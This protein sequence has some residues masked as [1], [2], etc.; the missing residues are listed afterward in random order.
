LTEKSRGQGSKANGPNEAHNDGSDG[1]NGMDERG[2]SEEKPASILHGGDIIPDKPGPKPEKAAAVP[3][4]RV[5]RV[6]P[7]GKLASPNM[8]NASQD[9]KPTKET[10]RVGSDG[11]LGSPKT[12]EAALDT[13][14]KRGRKPTETGATP[15][16]LVA[17][18]R[19]GTDE[20]SRSVIGRRVDDV[21]SG[22]KITSSPAKPK[23]SGPPGPPK[24]TH[25]FFLGGAVRSSDRVA[26]SLSDEQQGVEADVNSPAQQRKVV[27]PMKARVT[28][29]LAEF[30]DNAAAA[31][32]F[33][34]SR[35]GSDQ[36]RGSLFPGAMEPIWPPLSMLHVGQVSELPRLMHLDWPHISH[37]RTSCRK[38][39]GGEIVV[40]SEEEVLRPCLDLVRAYKVDKTVS[41]KVESCD[42]S[43]FRRPLR[44]LM[45]GYALQ[46]AVSQKLSA[47]IPSLHLDLNG[48][49]DVDE[50][51]SPQTHQ[52]QPH[53]ALRQVFEQIPISSTA[54]D[55]FE[56]E[57]QD[58]AHKYSP[59][60]AENVLQQGREVYLLRD[61]LRGLTVSSIENSDSRI[62]ESSI[63]CKFG[64]KAS[65]RKRRRAEKLEG[66][67]VSS[68]GESNQMDEI[69]DPEDSSSAKPPLR[70]TVIRG[71]NS[72]GLSSICDRSANAVV[73]S[74]PHGCGKTAAVYAVAQ[75]LNF[76]VFEINA[77]S[78]RS[79]KDIL[80]KVG[81]MTRNHLVKHASKEGAAM[82]KD[83]H[84]E[85]GIVNEKSKQD[86]EFGRHGKTNNF[87]KAKGPTKKKEPRSK[88]NAMKTSP[89]KHK[90]P[91]KQ[92]TQKQSLILLEEVDVLFEEDK[93][94]W[95]TILDLILHSKRP[96]IMT[97]TDEDFLPLDE[98]VLYAIL[99][100]TAPPEQFAIDYLLLI[101]CNEGHLLSRVAVS[102]LYR[103][104]GSDLRASM[105]EL[106]FFCQMAIGDTRGG[107]EWMLIRP[108]VDDSKAKK[109]EL[110][111]VVSDGTYQPFMGW[112]SGEDHLSETGNLID[113]EIELLSEVW[114]GWG[115]DIGASTQYI[116]GPVSAAAPQ[117]SR[118]STLESL[119]SFDQAAEALSAT[120]IFP[121]CVVRQP[122]N[123]ILEPALPEMTEKT[124]SNYVEGSNVLLADP[125]IDYG[126]VAESLSLTMRVCAKRLLHGSLH[127][128]ETLPSTNNEP[129]IARILP[130]IM[131]ERRSTMPMTKSSTSATFEPIARSTEP[132]LGV[133]KGLQIS[134]FDRPMS[135]I[136]VDLA[137]YLRNIV[138]YD[139]RLE[140][141]RR[142][143]DSL[144]PGAGKSGKN[145]RTT[146]SSR[147]ALEG[148]QKAYTRRERWFLNNTN[149]NLVLRSGGKDWQDA[150]QRMTTDAS[151]EFTAS[152]DL[153]LSRRSSVGSAVESDL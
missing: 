85:S 16:R 145:A 35:F 45:T 48:E 47:N 83:E 129:S 36:A 117:R 98:M 147:A 149:V 78:R 38:L 89:Q 74:G 86:L 137:P 9:V 103:A 37:A 46:K 15:K 50:L 104:K 7:D 5:L 64:S 8:K 153:D 109:T 63:S 73:I 21:L 80:D 134:S 72:A 30:A 96:I 107:L 11:K 19:Y 25:P 18:L 33:G 79:G 151:G 44:R 51:S 65:K 54:F 43:K 84:E 1:A 70:K 32:P 75:E 22:R 136:A 108:P 127:G 52:L 10:L 26:S 124:R 122:D 29:K 120:D 41:P 17:V 20:T 114:N 62:R 121:A 93:L 143:L 119:Q 148:G 125:F 56:C 42:W 58:W 67:V 12:K 133:P 150:L 23:V 90:A 49:Q 140:E 59:K 123:V 31:I 53:K 4:K 76:E 118:V 95:P 57:T 77:G 82:S 111:R 66:F 142:Q 138:S 105:A 130:D 128:N 55:R 152:S 61:W 106:N 126:G 132:V 112:L 3:P 40:P 24:A 100:F 34:G 68:D 81:D 97:C 69:T 88:G 28:S 146:R 39:K 102:A 71:G 2:I 87:F 113:L 101:A 116:L 135:V 115:I 6:R 13:K 141:Q 139:L 110:L 14:R 144:L 92:Q 94:F 99:R 91:K 60:T 131:Q 27:S